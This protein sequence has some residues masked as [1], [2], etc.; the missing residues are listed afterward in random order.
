MTLSE[1]S[2]TRVV[3]HNPLVDLKFFIIYYKLIY[4]K[5]ILILIYY[6]GCMK[7]SLCIPHG[8]HASYKWKPLILTTPI[9]V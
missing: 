9:P 3:F 8:L 1:D 7:T 2:T 5:G 4:M 6:S